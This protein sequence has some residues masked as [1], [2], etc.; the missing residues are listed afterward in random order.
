LTLVF[1][2]N[3]DWSKVYTEVSEYTLKW[4]KTEE[5]LLHS[6]PIDEVKVNDIK[7]VGKLDGMT[8]NGGWILGC[9]SAYYGTGRI[10]VE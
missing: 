9:I 2:L 8:D 1:N 7:M 3:K 5:L 4:D 6:K 10:I